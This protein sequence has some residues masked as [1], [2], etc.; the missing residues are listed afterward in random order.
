MKDL[1]ELIL[2]FEAYDKIPVNPD[3][4]TLLV[5]GIDLYIKRFS[6]PVKVL[7]G[8]N[9]LE[10]PSV[11]LDFPKL[12]EYYKGSDGLG[13]NALRFI[14]DVCLLSLNVHT[15]DHFSDETLLNTLTDPEKDDPKSES[16][17]RLFEEF[18][19]LKSLLMDVPEVKGSKVITE[20]I[21]HFEGKF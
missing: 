2:G 21:R 5:E 3:T 20:Q 7:R 9:V 11:Y 12:I 16:Y 14:S 15:G 19:H 4:R 13:I 18:Q 8:L 6:E 17:L 10:K 1:I